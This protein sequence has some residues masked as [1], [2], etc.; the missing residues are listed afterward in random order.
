M[1]EQRPVLPTDFARAVAV[2]TAQ[3]EQGQTVPWNAAT[4]RTPGALKG[5]IQIADDFD[6]W[7]SSM[8]TL[9]SAP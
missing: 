8:V 9:F 3:L 1:N 5:K 6:A 7:D 2:G 4:I